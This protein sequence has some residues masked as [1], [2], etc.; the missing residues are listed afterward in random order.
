MDVILGLLVDLLK[1]REGWTLK[2]LCLVFDDL[3]DWCAS[4]GLLDG[5]CSTEV[6][7]FLVVVILGSPIRMFVAVFVK[8]VFGVSVG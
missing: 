8:F 7:S 6:H 1:E 5:T 3:G 2:V 4:T